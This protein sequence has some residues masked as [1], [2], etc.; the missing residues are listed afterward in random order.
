M[1][2]LRSLQNSHFK[3]LK[4][5]CNNKFNKKENEFIIEGIKEINLALKSNFKIKKMYFREENSF[6]LSLYTNK[7]SEMFFL[8]KKII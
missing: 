6:E 4:R 7:V 1:I 8:K 5:L 3:R 2:I